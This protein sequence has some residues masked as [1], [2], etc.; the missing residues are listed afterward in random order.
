MSRRERLLLVLGS[1]GALM[2]VVYPLAYRLTSEQGD[3]AAVTAPSVPPAARPTPTSRPTPRRIA[4]P[5]PAQGV[6]WDATAEGH[7]GEN[8]ATFTYD[9]PPDGESGVI[10]GTDV[11]TDDSSVCTAGVHRGVITIE[12][13]GPV[14]IMIR[15]GQVAYVGS[16]RNGISTQSFEWWAG[17]FEVMLP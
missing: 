3:A 16:V 4:T 15:P 10:W 9:C 5:A 2:L 12:D 17:S 14:R 13:G 7:R 11:Y 6:P 1:V 8:G